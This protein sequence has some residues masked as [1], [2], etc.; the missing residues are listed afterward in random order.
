MLR[1]TDLRR[2]NLKSIQFGGRPYLP[3]EIPIMS[4][5]Y[6]PDGQWLATATGWDIM[7]WNNE[8]GERRRTLK[9]DAWIRCV[10]ISHDQMVISGD[11]NGTVNLWGIDNGKLIQTLKDHIQRVT[12]V[13]ISR[14]NKIVISG[15]ED[16]TVKLWDKDSGKLIKTLNSHCTKFF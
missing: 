6:S 13:A 12:S 8:T 15:I 5:A 2:A 11:D 1:K 16:S 4:I 7:L 3:H 9:G 10:V 14:N